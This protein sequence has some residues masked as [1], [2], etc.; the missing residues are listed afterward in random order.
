MMADQRSHPVRPAPANSPIEV[1]V[2]AFPAA[3]SD[4]ASESVSLVVADPPWNNL[5]A[6]TDIGIFAHHVLKPN[7]TLLAYIGNRWAFDAIDRLGTQLTRVRLGFLPEQHENPW[8]PE[9]LCEEMGSFIAILAK[10]RLEPA[11]PWKNMVE[12]AIQGHRWHHFQRPL[13]NVRHYVS[14]FSRIGDLVVDPFLGS[15]TTAVACAQLTRAFVG[16]DIDP[17]N[18]QNTVERLKGLDFVEHP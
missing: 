6:W 16:C 4:I 1:R 10:G 17:L 14:A 8:D 11:E 15:G 5:E 13:A 18:V 9:T 12:S 3:L 2:G 7:G